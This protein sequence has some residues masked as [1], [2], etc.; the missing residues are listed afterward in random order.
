ME[1]APFQREERPMGGLVC[2]LSILQERGEAGDGE[3]RF[4]RSGSSAKEKGY[5]MMG[6]PCGTVE[7]GGMNG[8]KTWKG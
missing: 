1:C 4:E 3:E 8:H 5:L 6:S 7:E 2:I